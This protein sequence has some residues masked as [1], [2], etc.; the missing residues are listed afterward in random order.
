[1]SQQIN[2]Y[3]PLFLKREKYFS[4]RTMAQALGLIALGLLAL[5][6]YAF[7][8]TQ[9]AERVAKQVQSQLGAQR[10]QLVKL[11]AGLAPR[12]PSK[13]LESEV[14][15]LEG[16]VRARRSVLAALSAGE[17]GNTEGFSRYL[18]AF[19]RQA[20]RGVWLTGFSVGESG[21]DLQLRGRV[22]HAELVPA[23]LR[24]LNAEPVMRGRQV[25]ELRLATKDTAAAPPPGGEKARA[26]GPQ[27]FVEFSVTAPQLAPD[28]A[29]PA[30]KKAAP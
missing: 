26:A 12:G 30:A 2:L 15:R 3:N 23:Y 7:V 22:V 17:L 6:A 24:A 16:E 9:S 27:R 4:A 10:E 25:T 1:M 29:K 19:G 11:G 14:T 20:L 28:P 18:A 21:S 13:L 5:F 8:Q